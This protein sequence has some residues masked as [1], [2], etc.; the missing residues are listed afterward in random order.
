MYDLPALEISD[1]LPTIDVLMDARGWTPGGAVSR[2]PPGAELEA[3]REAAPDFRAE[4]ERSGTA[5]GV[6][7][8][9]LITLPYPTRFG[10]W[11]AITSRA[12]FVSI[13]N[14]ML[15]VQW[16]DGER[17]RTLLWEPSDHERGEFTPYFSAL[18]AGDPMPTPGVGRAARLTAKVLPQ[19]A[20]VSRHGSVLGHL[21]ALGIDPA[22]VDYLSFD[23]LH[24]Q[25]VRRLIGTRAPAPD[26]GAADGPVEPWFP[27]A[28]LIVQA[29]E[30]DAL[31]HLHP[32]QAAWFQPQTYVD[33]P[34]DR[35]TL[36]DGDVQLG[37]GV[38]LLATPG[39]TAGNQS[40]VV[41]TGT[42]IWT[43][44]ENGIA[45][46]SWHP[47]A[48]QL[49]G[50]RDWAAAWGHEV[51]LNANTVEFASWQYN[52]MVAESLIAD[53]EPQGVF[54]QCFPS[55]EL[56]PSALPGTR[57]TRTFG[58]ITHGTVRASSLSPAVARS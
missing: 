8:C 51:V 43:S 29:R 44:S 5:S 4:I 27:N 28:R 48:S 13:T 25:D 21:K 7:T 53:L 6:V 1:T 23:H 55:S 42:G 38:A 54:P 10:F 40:L 17:I 24:T 47:A 11:R 49:P 20:L 14:R 56:T 2:T 9:D 30:W 52:H 31:R 18:G 32:F 39:H 36:V 19:S 34:P 57:P 33:L 58:A 46:E 37:P 22:D 45:A 41:R 35:I 15:V 50:I 12:P 3:L 16:E 26:L